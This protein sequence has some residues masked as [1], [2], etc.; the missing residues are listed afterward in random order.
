[1]LPLCSVEYWD[2]TVFA[3]DVV[4]LFL[5]MTMTLFHRTLWLG[6]VSVMLR[7][8]SVE[9]WDFISWNIVAT[10]FRQILWLY[11]INRCSFVPSDVVTLL[12]WTLWLY[13]I[14]RC[15][16]VPS[17]IKLWLCSIGHCDFYSID[18]CGF[19]PLDIMTLLHWTLW[20]YSIDRC[21]FFFFR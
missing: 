15:G 5:Q 13:S 11:S 17:D 1:M 16:F 10:V 19:V 9:H 14:D 18:R 3:L 20:L 4:V 7:L 6:S 12:H 8:G 2:V 21:G